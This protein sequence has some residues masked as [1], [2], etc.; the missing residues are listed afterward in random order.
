MPFDQKRIPFHLIKIVREESELEDLLLDKEMVLKLFIPEKKVIFTIKGE[1]YEGKL[2][3]P[4]LHQLAGRMFPFSQAPEEIRKR[5]QNDAN[6]AFAYAKRR[7]DI[8]LHSDMR[9]VEGTLREVLLR[10]PHILRVHKPTKRV[11][12]L[13]TDGFRSVNQIDVYQEILESIQEDPNLKYAFENKEKSLMDHT[14]RPGIEWFFEREMNREV[15][16]EVGLRYAIFFGKNNG[17]SAFETHL[18][19]H[20]L[21][22]TNGLTLDQ[23]E[24]RLRWKHNEQEPIREFISR[25]TKQSLLHL[26]RTQI[27]IERARSTKLCGEML[28]EFLRRLN[29]APASKRRVISRIKKENLVTGETEWSLSQAL[30][31]LAS[32]EKALMSRPKEYLRKAGTGIL[33][34]SLERYLQEEDGEYSYEGFYSSP[35]LPKKSF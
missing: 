14:G 2:D 25:C 12:G 35:L 7:W 24:G 3:R 21:I 9:A 23:Q 28:H 6:A 17:Y 32:H 18:E 11:Y 27:C 4:M 1:V 19:R 8:A 31:W 26:G 13:V 33:E 29:L 22:C 15:G 34:R 10:R 16:Q 30:T 20:I 5:Q